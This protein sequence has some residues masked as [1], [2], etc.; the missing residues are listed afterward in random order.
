MKSVLSSTLELILKQDK[1]VW[2]CFVWDPMKEGGWGGAEGL[3]E[4]TE[5]DPSSVV[6]SFGKEWGW[7][8]CRQSYSLW[9]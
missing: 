6:T 2:F 8:G 3:V 4:P 7:L 5:Q 1:L 9:R